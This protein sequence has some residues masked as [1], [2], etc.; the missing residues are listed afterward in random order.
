MISC[1]ITVLIVHSY[2]YLNFNSRFQFVKLGP[3][4]FRLIHVFL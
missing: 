2:V 3:E 4:Y 1:Y